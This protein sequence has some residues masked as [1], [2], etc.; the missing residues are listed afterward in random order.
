MTRAIDAFVDDLFELVHPTLPA[1]LLVGATRLR[2]ARWW[3]LVQG[4]R[5]AAPVMPFLS[6]HLWRNLVAGAAEVL[7]TRVPR[8]LA[9]RRRRRRAARPEVADTRRSSSSVTRLA[10][11]PASSCGSPW[12]RVRP[13]AD[14]ASRHAAEIGEELNV[15]EVLFDEGPVVRAQLKPNLP[16]LGPRLGVACR[17]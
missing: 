4:V 15:K 13:R 14:G 5:A 10:E 16:L 8:R 2:S 3:A 9:R 1:P 17:L 12:P 7:Q 6:D 11:T